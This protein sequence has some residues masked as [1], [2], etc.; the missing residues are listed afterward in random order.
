[1]AAAATVVLADVPMVGVAWG[2]GGDGER[3]DGGSRMSHGDGGVVD[4]DM[5]GDAGG[6]EGGSIGGS[7]GGGGNGKGSEEG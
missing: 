5:G 2:P 7:D 6:G 1:M 3:G 4:R